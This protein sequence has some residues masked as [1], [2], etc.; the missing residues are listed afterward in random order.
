MADVDEVEFVRRSLAI[1]G[2]VSAARFAAWLDAWDGEGSFFRHLVAL[3]VLERPGANTLAAVSKGYVVLAPAAL[4]GLFKLGAEPR[5]IDPGPVS[6]DRSTTRGPRPED[7]LRAPAERPTSRGVG[8]RPDDGA[9]ALEAVVG[10]R[11]DDSAAAIEAVP[12]DRSP[13]LRPT[14]DEVPTPRPESRPEPV[15][16][17]ERSGP[18]ADASASRGSTGRGRVPAAARLGHA[19]ASSPELHAAVAAA[20]DAALSGPDEPT[21]RPPILEQV[22]ALRERVAAVRGRRAGAGDRSARSGAVPEDRSTGAVPED[23][24]ARSGAVPED[25]S[26]GAVPKDR[27]ARSG[28]VPEDRST[29]AVPKDRSARSGAVPEDRSAAAVPEDTA[30]GAA[31]PD[32]DGLPGLGDVVAGYELRAALGRGASGA[33]YRAWAAA[34]GRSVV[35]KLL[36]PDGDPTRASAAA[37]AAVHWRL[38]HPGVVKLL[39]AGEHDGVGYLVFEDL[40]AQSLAEYLEA[41]GPLPSAR[42]AQIGVDV[43]QTLAAAAAVGVAHGDL[44][45]ANLLV[46]GPEL[47][48][49]LTDFAAP[50]D[51]RATPAYL[52]PERAVRPG[53]ADARADMYSLGATLYHAA[54][55]RPPFVRAS[56]DTAARGAD[57]A[58]PVHGLL[59]GFSRAVSTVIGRLLHRQPE[60]RFA[61][62]DEVVDALVAAEPAVRRSQA[63]PEDM[64]MRTAEAGP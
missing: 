26:P 64:S 28:A 57:E 3:G 15:G 9:A 47:R 50:D 12:E 35:L 8:P 62:W 4:L 55:G 5:P 37:R 54:T 59:R 33:V 61:R 30:S 32:A 7:S 39:A 22:A 58:L 34:P 45:P 14:A 31:R 40:Y 42:V 49:K 10:P 21:P 20:V 48:I 36:R 16:R 19:S 29:G 53:P 51:P 18:E 23:R 1:P 43:A 17:A 44:K 52:A 63:G 25:R 56:R 13:T 46:Y 27:S 24:S 6:P 60:A 38:Q 41:H 11:P 2:L